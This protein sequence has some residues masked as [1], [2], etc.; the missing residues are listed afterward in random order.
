MKV[1]KVKNAKSQGM[2]AS[3]EGKAVC[4]NRL[5]IRVDRTRI[6]ERMVLKGLAE[7]K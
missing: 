2:R 1:V 4:Q 5:G 6:L 7:E 3:R